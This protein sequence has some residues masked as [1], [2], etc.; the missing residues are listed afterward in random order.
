VE[1]QRLAALTPEQMVEEDRV[2][3]EK[4][5][6][7]AK[8]AAE[9]AALQRATE[10]KVQAD[11]AKRTTQLQMAGGGAAI[12]KRAMKDPEAFDLRSLVVKPNGTACYEYRAKNS[13]GAVLPS[14]AVLTPKGRM[15]VQEQD[16]NEFVYAWNKNCTVSGGDE[17][18]DLVKRLGII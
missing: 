5:A 8:A 14:S 12:L 3:Q 2:K 10:A 9:A 11:K 1:R 17:I 4:A 18:A 7:A 13:F 6:A 15:L 16:G